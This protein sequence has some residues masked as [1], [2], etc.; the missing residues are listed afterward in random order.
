MGSVPDMP[1]LVELEVGELVP[2]EAVVV[3][4]PPSPV[5]APAPLVPVFVPEPPAPESELV[6]EGSYSHWALRLQR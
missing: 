6:P 2:V 3:E 4:A 1:V 5:E